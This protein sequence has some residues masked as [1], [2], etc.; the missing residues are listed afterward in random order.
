MSKRIV[1]ATFGS[2]GDVNPYLGLALGLKQRGH[3][4]VIAIAEFYRSYIKGEGIEFHPLRP[5]VNP[6]EANTMQHVMDPNWG[7]ST[8]SRSYFSLE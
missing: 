1:L 7:L 2:Y 8:F 4:P 5:D 6:R 3:C